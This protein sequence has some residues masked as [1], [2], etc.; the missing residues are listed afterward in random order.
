MKKV[1]LAFLVFFSAPS[2]ADYYGYHHHND[3][4]P[5]IGIGLLGLTI[6]IGIGQSY[7]APPQPV[8]VPPQPV[9]APPQPVYT[10]PSVYYPY[11]YHY[12]TLWDPRCYCYKNVLVPN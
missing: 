1:L 2:Y 4:A 8:Y 10:P 5:A 6:G 7:Y 3:W 9:Y 12:V 11:G